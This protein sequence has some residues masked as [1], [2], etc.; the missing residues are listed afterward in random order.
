MTRLHSPAFATASPN[1]P[2]KP[3][4]SLAIAVITLVGTI[5]V[6]HFPVN[7]DVSWSLTVADKI[8][9]GETL[10]KSI[11]EFNPPLFFTLA[12]AARAGGRLLGT[13]PEAVYRSGVLTAVLCSSFAL[14]RWVPC[15]A[16]RPLVFAFIGVALLLVGRDFG[17]R[18]HISM[19]LLMPSL[20]HGIRRS[21]AKVRVQTLVA[22]AA[23]AA[24]VLRPFYLPILFL[25]LLL[26]EHR[27]PHY[28]TM[29][30]GSAYLLA[31]IA[32]E[33]A[34]VQAASLFATV[35]YHWI[36]IPWYV[37]AISP[38][39]LLAAGAALAAH[40]M[41]PRNDLA[42][43]LSLAAVVGALAFIAQGKPFAYH[44]LPALTFSLLAFLAIGAFHSR[45]RLL[46]FSMAG[47]AAL[48]IGAPAFLTT[49]QVARQEQS[50]VRAQ[51]LR[52][53]P[54]TRLLLWSWAIPNGF[55]ASRD[56]NAW[57]VGGTPSVWWVEIPNIPPP[58]E[59]FLRDLMASDL[60][61]HP[62]I[63]AIDRAVTTR[64]RA[65]GGF[66]L[67]AY[68]LRDA[69][70]SAMLSKEYGTVD[71][72]GPLYIY[73]RVAGPKQ[74]SRYRSALSASTQWR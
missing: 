72:S 49:D 58:T 55:P 3:S 8:S 32:F 37:L 40:L 60:A 22:A 4:L 27:F 1:N 34:F 68:I 44:A 33:P 70:I 2:I 66:D 13:S 10:Y 5:A 50:A 31:V 69:R 30:L 73:R 59:R 11:L 17:E 29:A 21:P 48:A 36:G 20:V 43:R 41:R 42:V 71:S 24:Y 23:A 28:T 35:Y 74:G 25:L 57:W 18:D 47:T 9:A 51:L 14:W 12:A 61:R 39:G 6:F 62:D 52:E 19:V 26:D 56:A 38:T 65:Y 7:H 16:R 64:R 53:P 67:R 63:V 54:G 15:N 45:H 46:M